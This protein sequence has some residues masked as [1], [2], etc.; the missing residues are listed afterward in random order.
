MWS[1]LRVPGWHLLT[2]PLTGLLHHLLLT[3]TDISQ[4]TDPICGVGNM[5]ANASAQERTPW[6]VTIK[7]PRRRDGAW[8][9]EV[10]PQARDIAVPKIPCPPAAQEPGD[11]PGGPHL[12]PVGPDSRSLLKQCRGQNTVEGQCG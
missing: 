6:H 2:V 11:L 7:V 9:P 8:I 5:S 4:L 12:R 10:W 3:P 1:R